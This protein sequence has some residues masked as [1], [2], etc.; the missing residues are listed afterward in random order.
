[1]TQTSMD[2]QKIGIEKTLKDVELFALKYP[3]EIHNVSNAIKLFLET[4][5]E[6][7]IKHLKENGIEKAPAY[8][9]E[10]EVIED[11]KNRLNDRRS[12]INKA[13]D[14]LTITAEELKD[15]ETLN[16]KEIRKLSK[17]LREAVEDIY[18]YIGIAPQ[19]IER[20]YKE[21]AKYMKDHPSEEKYGY[22]PML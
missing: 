4:R 22:L 7:I 14:I 17:T 11:R 3:Q 21:T 1:M 16:R 13:I 19:A 20:C 2:K 18:Y 15:K 9:N 5:E 10:K 12:H 6:V 8:K